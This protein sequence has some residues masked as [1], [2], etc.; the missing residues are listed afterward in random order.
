MLPPEIFKRRHH[1]TPETVKLISINYVVFAFAVQIFVKCGLIN[2]FF[3]VVLAALAWYNYYTIRRN[4]DEFNQTNKIVFFVS[5]A[6]LGIIYYLIAV[7]AQH[8]K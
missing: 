8:C 7:V 5:I 2:W 1:G 3:W 6:G 4:R